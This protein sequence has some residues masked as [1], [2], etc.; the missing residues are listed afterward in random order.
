MPGCLRNVVKFVVLPLLAV[1]LLA[2][3][4]F[5]LVVGPWPVYSDAR[6]RERAWFQDTLAALDASAARSTL[7]DAPGR[8]RAGWAERDMTPPVG[9][10]LGGYSGRP[11]N[12]RSTGVLDPVF[13]RAIV[14]SDG[15]DTVAIVGSDLLMT[16]LNLARR[17]WA[18]VADATPLDP[19]NILFTTSHTHCGAGGYMPG[20]LGEYSAGTY[21]EETEI[22][23]ASAMAGAIRDAH[24][25]LAPAAMAHGTVDAPEFIVNRTNVPGVDSALDY[26]ILRK[27]DGGECHAL[28]YSAH[29]T[30]LPDAFLEISA[31]YP[32]ALARRV[33]EETG[34]M[35][36]FLGGAVGAMGPNPPAGG[37]AVARMRA[38]GGGLAARYL[39]AIRA[40]PPVFRER[41]DIA[42]AG[43]P[44]AMPP[45]QA[46]PFSARWR[47]SPLM[48]H[49]VGLPPEGWIQAVRAGDLVIMG[50]PYDAGGAISARWREAA[51]ARGAALW[52]TSHAI[53]YC[54]YLNP[55]EYYSR[56]PVGY[57]QHYEWRM[58]DWFG[59]NQEGLYADLKEHLLDRLLPAP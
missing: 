27:E 20:L 36:V 35:A 33:A 2:A 56:E 9:T 42:F 46:R 8:L 4:L 14:L 44:V 55:A 28:R 12:K 31:E 11:N 43:G 5:V 38:M 17:V 3:G 47:L 53:A 49:V 10:P 22:L 25:A 23:I 41:V 7:S 26:L 6:H 37:D 19:H 21:A 32:G 58:M 39:D 16:T 40:D 30:I 1:A 13:A 45:M 48:A 18:E 59:P 50:F 29:A 51:A 57:D 24:A 54:G 15:V 34:A 52:V